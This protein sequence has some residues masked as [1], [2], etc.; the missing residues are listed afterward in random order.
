M[1]LN[2]KERER[3]EVERGTIER[4]GVDVVREWERKGEKELT[5]PLFFI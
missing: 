2:Q 3:V 1:R 5:D 4:G